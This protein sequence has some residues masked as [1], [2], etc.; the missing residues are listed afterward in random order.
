MDKEIVCNLAVLHF[1]IGSA[2]PLTNDN[3]IKSFK[4]AFSRMLI[5][6]RRKKI[7]VSR[8]MIAVPIKW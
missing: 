4:Q 5:Y 8:Q 7:V 2:S 1:V 6:W 3:Q